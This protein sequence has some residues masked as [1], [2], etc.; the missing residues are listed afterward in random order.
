MKNLLKRMG[1]LLVPFIM[2]LTGLLIGHLTGV[3]W[4]GQF[5]RGKGGGFMLMRPS[6]SFM[7]V[8]MHLNSPNPFARTGAYYSLAGLEVMEREDLIRRYREERYTVLKRTILWTLGERMEKGSYAD[9]CF[10]LV[11]AR[12]ADEIRLILTT[13][14]DRYP[15]SFPEMLEKRKGKLPDPDKPG[16]KVRVTDC[17]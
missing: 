9:L 5:L 7:E 14:R 1:P 15:C 16:I 6:S 13:L 17:P 8:Y 4:S 10:T 2:L 11:E 3:F 12:G